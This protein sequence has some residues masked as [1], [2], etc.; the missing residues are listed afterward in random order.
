MT[1]PLKSIVF[2]YLLAN[3]TGK[4][5]FVRTIVEQCIHSTVSADKH[6]IVWYYRGMELGVLDWFV[7]VFILCRAILIFLKTQQQ[8]F[9][10]VSILG[11]RRFP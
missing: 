1:K 9:K 2:Q 6:L 11:C 5:T 8:S 4:S 10:N 7:F 3:L